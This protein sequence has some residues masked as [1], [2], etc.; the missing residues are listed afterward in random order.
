MAKITAFSFVKISKGKLQ[1]VLDQIIKIK[2]VS[3][4][5]VLTGDYDALV[6]FDIDDPQE[7]YEIWVNMLDSIEGITETNTHIVMK[8]VT[9]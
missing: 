5:F 8:K 7:L 3:Q 9:I 6:E 2:K 4:L 1:S